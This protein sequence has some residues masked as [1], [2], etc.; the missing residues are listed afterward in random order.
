MGRGK[1]FCHYCNSYIEHYSFGQRK[2]HNSG[3][4]HMLNVRFYYDDFVENE[5]Q[6]LIDATTEAYKNGTL[7][8]PVVVNNPPV[9]VLPQPMFPTAMPMLSVPV[10]PMI[11]YAMAVPS[12]GPPYHYPGMI[13]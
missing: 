11:G 13:Q 10:P 8:Q 12:I 7:F 4:K 5:A 2:S 1:Y 9:F 3:K 6:K